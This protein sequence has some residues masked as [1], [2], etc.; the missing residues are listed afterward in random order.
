M[1]LALPCARQ[2]THTHTV[3]ITAIT[4]TH[5]HP[6][7]CGRRALVSRR[8][9][10]Y[11]HKYY[12][13]RLWAAAAAAVE[14]VKRFA[15]PFGGQQCSRKKNKKKLQRNKYEKQTHTHTHTHKTCILFQCVLKLMVRPYPRVRA[16]VRVHFCVESIPHFDLRCADKRGTALSASP[17]RNTSRS[18][19]ESALRWCVVS[20]YVR[21]VCV[22][23][24]A[25][26]GCAAAA[27]EG[28]EI[29]V[30]L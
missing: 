5:H 21:C 20:S 29:M 24:R 8:S 3:P 27:S 11:A 26:R 12:R 15:P 6:T 30:T 4:T 28:V 13:T 14:W 10:E 23:V 25:R 1:A 18:T 22:C 2:H 7:S 16:L 17:G 9:G 19:P